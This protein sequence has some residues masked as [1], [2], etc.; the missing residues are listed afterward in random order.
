[1][2]DRSLRG[3]RAVYDL[4]AAGQAPFYNVVGLADPT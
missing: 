4:S 3:E 2:L 1:V